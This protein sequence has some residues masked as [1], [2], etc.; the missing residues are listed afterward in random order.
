M[1]KTLVE[2]DLSL[3]DSFSAFHDANKDWN[4][5]SYLNYKYDM[6]AA[7]AFSKFFFPDFTEVRGCVV[8]SF[9]YNPETFESWFSELRGEVSEVEKMANLYEIKDFFHINTPKKID[10]DAFGKILKKSWEINLNA[11][12]PQKKFHVKLFEEYDSKFITFHTS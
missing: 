7:L 1:N 3:L 5:L 2:L 8:I 9:L 11:L 10:L 4:I 12:Y 6:N